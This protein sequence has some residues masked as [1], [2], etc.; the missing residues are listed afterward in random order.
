M[1][2]IDPVTG[3]PIADTTTTAV[4][5]NQLKPE[6][7]LKITTPQ[8]DTSLYSNALNATLA[9][10]SNGVNTQQANVD[11]QNK[12]A[13]NETSALANLQK[14]LGN[15]TQ[16]LSS[17]YQNTGVND[18]FN[19]LKDL[20][21]QAQGLNLNAQAIPLQ[22]QNQAIGTGRV[23]SQ[24]D[25]ISSQKLRDNALKALSLG[26]QAAIASANYDKAKNYADQI[27]EAKYAGLEAEIE[28]KKTNL[29]ALDKYV[30]T[31]AQQK[32]KDSQA[33][34]LKRQ[35]Q[36]IADKKANE[37]DIQTLSLSIAKNGAPQSVVAKLS[38]AKTF[39]DAVA[40]ASPYL[41]SAADKADLSY[42]LAQTAKIYNDMRNDNALTTDP[43]Q[44]LAYAQQYAST[45][46]I[47]TG[48]PKGS[49][50]SIAM[51]AKELPKPKGTLVDMNTGVK[52][53]KLGAEE[54]KGIS[55][56]YDIVNNKLPLLLDKFN[57]I[58]TGV[59]GGT[60]G[61]VFTSQDRQDFE[62][63]RGEILNLLLQAR[64]GATVSPQEYDRYSALIPTT[65]NQAFFLGSDG[66]KKIR[67]LQN[68]LD[69]TLNSKLKT[70]GSAIYGYSKVDIGGKEYTVG[71]IITSP[72]G[73]SG[74]INPDGTVTLIQ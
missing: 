45:G 42:K 27:V 6:T 58:N 22:E 70:S 8:V 47:P 59:V 31:P 23:Q 72:D 17:T 5:T 36:E 13:Q 20:N 56:T 28:A 60:L 40:L 63:T 74:R 10:L 52:P 43:H 48:I 7:P 21:A 39:N 51:Y 19:Q 65:F 25:A 55:A 64:S 68:S 66:E 16:D 12:Q 35:E 71:D 54:E 53:S 46:Q 1:A 41:Q 4:S 69:A 26:Q 34:L 24:V 49:F 29:A 9:D 11:L 73:R 33:I 44:T 2:T 15:K 18:L 67:S 14:Q 30:L 3:L 62:T 61:Q 38:Q 32:L 57:K 37:K 50:G